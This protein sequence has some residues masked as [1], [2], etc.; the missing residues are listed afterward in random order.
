MTHPVITVKPQDSAPHAR[1]V[2]EEHRINQLSVLGDGRLVGIVTDRDLR[3]VFPSGSIRRDR[4]DVATAKSAR[5]RRRS[6]SRT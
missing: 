4:L 3:D 6:R 1:E 2:I 5:T